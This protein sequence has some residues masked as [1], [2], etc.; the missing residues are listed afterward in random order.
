MI[1]LF[2]RVLFYVLLDVLVVTII[3]LAKDGATSA[4]VPTLVAGDIVTGLLVGSF[5]YLFWRPRYR[6]A[7]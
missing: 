2:G 7:P 6:A 1:G 3:A 4:A 5:A